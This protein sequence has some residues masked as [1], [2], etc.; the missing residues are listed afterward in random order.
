[1]L[2]KRINNISEELS[3]KIE[4]FA[5]GHGYENAEYLCDWNGFKCFEPIFNEAQPSYLG[6]PLLILADA[7]DNIRMAT[8]EESIKHYNSQSF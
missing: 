7:K 1:M 6:A 3:R 8:Y 2:L 4:T 5:K